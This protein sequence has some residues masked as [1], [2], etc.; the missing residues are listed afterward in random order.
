MFFV[1]FWLVLK[2][3]NN[4]RFLVYIKQLSKFIKICK[5]FYIKLL[6]KFESGVII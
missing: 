6:T 3:K 4:S 2:K 5:I 1:K